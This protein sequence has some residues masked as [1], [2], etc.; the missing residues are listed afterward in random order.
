MEQKT[1]QTE[2]Y[3]LSASICLQLCTDPIGYE[4]IGNRCAA[5][6]PAT[7]EVFEAAKRY[8]SGIVADCFAFATKAKDIRAEMIK[9]CRPGAPR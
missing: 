5:V 9:R 7:D 8:H 4:Q 1:Y 3:F 6:F 2:D